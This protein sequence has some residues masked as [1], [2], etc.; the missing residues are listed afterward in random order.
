MLAFL[1]VL[2]DLDLVPGG[3]HHRRCLLLARGVVEPKGG[4]QLL[5]HRLQGLV[6]LGLKRVIVRLRVV[7][8]VGMLPRV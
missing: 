2:I 4:G 3:G 7:V 6:L 1:P 5:M 8:V